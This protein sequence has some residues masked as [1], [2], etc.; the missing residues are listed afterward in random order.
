L[1]ASFYHYNY[2]NPTNRHVPD[3]GKS[4]S[5]SP[6]ATPAML[7][8]LA[9]LS[10]DE[11]G[12]DEIL[13]DEYPTILPKWLIPALPGLKPAINAAGKCIMRILRHIVDSDGID[14]LR[15]DKEDRERIMD[16]LQDPHRPIAPYK[17]H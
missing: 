12:E 2:D 3:G 7:L 15:Q 5:V 6:I 1:G 9:Y 17:T 10:N 4:I 13:P 14:D 8:G 16:E 11:P